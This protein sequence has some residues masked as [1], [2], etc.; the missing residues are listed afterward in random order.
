MIKGPSASPSHDCNTNWNILTVPGSAIFCN[1]VMLIWS[2]IFSIPKL[3]IFCYGIKI[4]CYYYHMSFPMPSEFHISK[5][6]TS[7]LSFSFSATLLLPGTGTS[8]NHI[9]FS[10][11]Q[12][13][14]CPAVF[15]LCAH[16]IN[17]KTPT[18]FDS[19]IFINRIRFVIILL[20]QHPRQNT[21]IFSTLWAVT[22]QLLIMWLAVSHAALKTLYNST[23]E[24]FHM[25]CP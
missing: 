22:V 19:F 13:K 16:H 6:G 4:S 11:Y 5:V 8:I 15:L 25:I 2:Q 7:L 1:N 14:S 17:L 20:A 9:F 10:F 21:F 24:V 23:Y 3:Y 18:N 12:S